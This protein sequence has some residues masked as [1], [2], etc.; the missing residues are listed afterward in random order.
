M[1]GFSLGPGRHSPGRPL[2]KYPSAARF[3]KMGG[4]S[5]SGTSG[6]AMRRRSARRR[7][8]VGLC[9]SRLN[10]CWM[11]TAGRKWYAAASTAAIFPCA[12]PSKAKNRSSSKG[13]RARHNTR[14]SPVRRPPRPMRCKNEVRV[15]GGPISTT[16]SIVPMSMPNSRVELLTHR[17]TV[18]AA[19]RVSTSSRTSLSRLL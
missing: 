19:K 8:P 4:K 17:A 2:C 15:G 7:L 1:G 11:R 18:A 5:S 12:N 10:V 6:G 13:E 3:R 14:V 16:S 9:L